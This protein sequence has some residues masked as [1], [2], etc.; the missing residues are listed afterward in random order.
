MKNENAYLII[1]LLLTIV[2]FITLCYNVEI[3]L[4]LKDIYLSDRGY[5]D[6]MEL[7]IFR[8]YSYMCLIMG[9]IFLSSGMRV[10]NKIF[11]K[12]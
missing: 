5:G 9:G 7:Q 8:N 11:F 4:G 10:L 1:G 3:A 6:T 2:G 12:N